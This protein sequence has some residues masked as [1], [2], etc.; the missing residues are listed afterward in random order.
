MLVCCSHN[1]A[2]TFRVSVWNTF[3]TAASSRAVTVSDPAGSNYW[4][5]DAQQLQVVVK[6]STPIV[7]KQLPQVRI[8]MTLAISIEDF[9]NSDPKQFSNG[10]AFAL[11]INPETVRVTGY[12]RKGKQALPPSCICTRHVAET[13]QNRDVPRLCMPSPCTFIIA[14]LEILSSSE[15]TSKSTR[16][17]AWTCT[18]VNLVY[19]ISSMPMPLAHHTS[20]KLASAAH[21]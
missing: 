16:V 15:W 10:L 18:S 7:L 3:S 17:L 20:G 9:L 19:T 2:Q 14:A 11:G 8:S 12:K 13:L 21:V 1:V 4:D 5:L 6:G